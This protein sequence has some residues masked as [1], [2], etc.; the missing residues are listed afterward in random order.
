MPDAK[1]LVVGV[2][3]TQNV[4]AHLWRV[5]IAGGEPERL[6][7]VGSQVFQPSVSTAGHRLVAARREGTY[8]DIWRFDA[9]GTRQED[10]L[11]ST[12]SDVDPSFS[13]DGTRVAYATAR[14]GRDQEIWTARSDGS[15]AA[16]LTSGAEGRL[17]GTPRWSHDGRHI[18]FDSRD[19]DGIQRVYVIDSS[20]G[21]ARLAAPDR[22]DQLM[23][24]WSRDNRWIYFT[25]RQTG[26]AEIWRVAAEGGAAEQVTR[27]GGSG[28]LESPDGRTLYYR[29]GP[30]LYARPVAG[31][32]ERTVIEG[33]FGTPTA[34]ASVGNEIYHL[35][36]DRTPG[37]RTVEVRA[38]D[39]TTGQVRTI[40]RFRAWS[41]LGMTVSPDGRTV[42]LGVGRS[43]DTDLMLVENFR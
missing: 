36:A 40:S 13:P 26:R 8:F 10:F 23:A 15:N 18:V 31:G 5:P 17:R 1:S 42:L 41:A 4:I 30:V 25:S 32:P 2:T 29:R 19:T 9:S 20:G 35:V 38:T 7:S 6:E 12:M 37:V 3:L 27:E 11:S 21:P 16:P 14:S 28:A 34:Y 39:L 22:S 43:I 24:S 33:V